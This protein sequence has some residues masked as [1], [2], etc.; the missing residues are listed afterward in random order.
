[1]AFAVQLGARGEVPPAEWAGATAEFLGVG[2]VAERLTDAAR[3]FAAGESFE[4]AV[5]VLGEGIG[6]SSVVATAIYAAMGAASFEDAVFVAV[7]AGGATDARGA[8]AGAIAGAVRGAGGIPQWMID[9]LEGRIYV[10]LAAP[11]FHRTALRRSG[12]VI[13]LRRQ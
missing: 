5:A 9:D 11:W 13:D 6:A 12:L 3:M 7:D 10:S 2:E 4:R 1:V 8:I